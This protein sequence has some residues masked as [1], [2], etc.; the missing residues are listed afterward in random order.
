MKELRR[1]ET[2]SVV[3]AADREVKADRTH[4]FE[5]FRYDHVDHSLSHLAVLEGWPG[6]DIP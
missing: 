2:W 6:M 3:K 4:G 5:Q 1:K